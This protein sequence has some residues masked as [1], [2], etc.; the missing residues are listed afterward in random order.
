M[1]KRNTKLKS[2]APNLKILGDTVF[3]SNKPSDYEIFSFLR[4]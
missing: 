1:Y 2:I 3:L 4:N